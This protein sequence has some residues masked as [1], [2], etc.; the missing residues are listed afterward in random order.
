MSSPTLDNRRVSPTL[1]FGL[2]GLGYFGKHY[3]RL[4][5]ETEGIQLVAVASR[6]YQVFE[7][8]AQMLPVGVERYTDP[9]KIFKSTDIDCVVIAT[10]PST[11]LELSSAALASGKHVLLEKPMVLNMSEALRLNEAV[12]KSDRIFM[13]GHQ[14]LYNDYIRNLKT[15]LANGAIGQVKYFFAEH[16]YFEILR[17]DVGCFW[18]TAT[19]EFAILDYLF[20]PGE[21]ISSTGQASGIESREDFAS[22]SVKFASG[23]AGSIFVSWFQPEKIRRMTFS[24]TGGMALFDDRREKKLLFK[25]QPYPA[26]DQH[27]GSFFFDPKSEEIKVP[28]IQ[29]E[30]PLKAELAHFIECVREN[31]TP[32]TDIEHGLRV[33]RMLDR[34]SKSLKHF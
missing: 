29:A 27:K 4:L 7:K 2:I 20:N 32:R 21:V 34:V 28:E 33:T 17:N 22:A 5:Q 30:E 15:E 6:G 8:Y 13:I 1:R 11:H 24:G 26:V 23:L 12:K 14:Y 18:E 10:P 19:H 3:L 9:Q 25:L 31:K 16:Q